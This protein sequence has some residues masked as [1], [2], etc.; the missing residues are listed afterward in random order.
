MG[1]SRHPNPEVEKS[2]RHAESRGWRV[3]M[4]GGHAWGKLYCPYA[5]RDGCKV[6]VWSTP[7]SAGNHAQALRRKVDN[8]P[9]RGGADEA[10]NEGADDA[11]A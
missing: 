1:R 5:N 4:G 8:C 7:R 10:P 2:I 9:H 11:E 3:V 6:S